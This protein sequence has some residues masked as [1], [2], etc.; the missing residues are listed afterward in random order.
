[1]PRTRFVERVEL[2]YHVKSSN[3]LVEKLLANCSR[4]ARAHGSHVSTDQVGTTVPL[5]VIS[6]LLCPQ[7]E[8][9][10]LCVL[11]GLR[12]LVAKRRIRQAGVG[13]PWRE[14]GEVWV[15]V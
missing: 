7:R 14:V 9:P 4:L 13:V 1:M 6:D 2:R 12:S 5:K 15:I 3:D 11:I 8:F 10:G